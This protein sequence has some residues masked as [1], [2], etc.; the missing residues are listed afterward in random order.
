MQTLR[1]AVILDPVSPQNRPGSQSALRDPA[2]NDKQTCFAFTPFHG[3]SILPPDCPYIAAS[4]GSAAGLP[5]RLGWPAE[6]L[7]LYPSEPWRNAVKTRLIAISVGIL[8]LLAAGCAEKK[9]AEK[10]APK[11]STQQD[12]MALRTSIMDSYVNAYNAKDPA[13]LAAIFTD[14]A[15]QMHPDKPATIGKAAIEAGYKAELETNQK[16]YSQ[17]TYSETSNDA[18]VSGDWA[19]MAGAFVWSATPAA[20][21]KTVEIKGKW[22][23]VC[24]RQPGGAWKVTRACWNSDAPMPQAN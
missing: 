11:P 3:G 22:L 14:D 6:P 18:G 20:K 17:V 23:V 19:Y 9:E 12:V 7:E 8:S 16:L 15:V 24:Q 13:G 2:P 4:H 1:P 21:G 10:T 5:A